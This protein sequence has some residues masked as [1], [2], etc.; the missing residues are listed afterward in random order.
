MPVCKKCQQD[1]PE[2]E[3]YFKAAGR[4]ATSCK[5]CHNSQVKKWQEANKEKVKGYIRAYCRKSY[6]QNPEKHRDKSRVYPEKNLEKAM[7]T[8]W[9][10]YRKKQENLDEKEKSRRHRNAIKWRAE[11]IEKCRLAVK[12]HRERHPY[13]HNAKEAK[14]RAAKVRATPAWLT[15]IELAQIQEMYD[16]SIA[17]SMQTGIKHHVD[18]IVPLRSKLVTGLHVPW[19]L[20][21]IP[22]HENLKKNNKLVEI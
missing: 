9:K 2:V 18:H 7:R 15:F 21:I 19:N 22:A 8:K 10:S 20:R 4:L 12:T 5:V 3:F 14:R 16:L 17:V 11:N 1:K 13:K 6:A